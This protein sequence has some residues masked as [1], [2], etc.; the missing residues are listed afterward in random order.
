[1]IRLLVIN[2]RNVITKINIVTKDIINAFI[3]FI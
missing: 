2:K 1:M 3:H